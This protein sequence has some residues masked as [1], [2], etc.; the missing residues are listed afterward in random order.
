MKLVC[1]FNDCYVIPI[2]SGQIRFNVVNIRLLGSG[3]Y[4]KILICCRHANQI[5]CERK[6]QLDRATIPVNGL[7]SNISFSYFAEILVHKIN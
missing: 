7:K 2:R 4:G 3:P 1:I 6:S 5:L